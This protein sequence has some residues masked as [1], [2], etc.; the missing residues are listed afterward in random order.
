M[1]DLRQ[2]MLKSI[3]NSNPKVEVSVQDATKLNFSNDE[4]DRVI[5][6][7]ILEHL[8]NPH[9]VLREW[10]RVLKPGGILSILL[11]CDPGIA[12]RLGQSL[13]SKSNF[14]SVGLNYDYINAREHINSIGNLRVL[15]DFYFP[16]NKKVQ[17]EPLKI[18]Y[19]DLN[20][21]YIVHIYI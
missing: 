14:S 5:A 20:L 8:P 11:P 6:A 18:P 15:I 9:L 16:E 1:S 10:A 19:Y 21:F 17:W 3:D 4:F 12:W 2:E 7:H 13:R